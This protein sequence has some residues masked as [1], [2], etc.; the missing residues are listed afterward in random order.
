MELQDK[1]TSLLDHLQ[2]GE[3]ELV[4]CL[5]LM[6]DLDEESSK[7]MFSKLKVLEGNVSLLI[8]E[9][10]ELAGLDIE[11][12]SI[13]QFMNHMLKLEYRSVFDYML[14]ADSVKDVDLSNELRDLGKTEVEHT[15]VLI[16]RIRSEGGI[17]RLNPEAGVHA[18]KM[19]VRGILE[20][21]LEIGEQSKNLCKKGLSLF[22]GPDFQWVFQTI[23]NDEQKHVEKLTNLLKTLAELETS[24]LVQS[25][26][27]HPQDIDFNSDEPWIDG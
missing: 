20:K 21:Q 25:R 18:K 5:G 8:H 3:S 19:T 11:E 17:P 2:R 14:F 6:E 9:A 22:Q 12:N 16:N 4:S 26:Y 1:L 27:N 15:K 23:M 10:K 7:E 13:I 24:V